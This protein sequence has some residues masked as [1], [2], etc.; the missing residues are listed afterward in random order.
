[1]SLQGDGKNEVA[2]IIQNVPVQL[3]HESGRNRTRDA[4]RSKSELLCAWDLVGL[5]LLGVCGRWLES[6]G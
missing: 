1:M 4:N 2:I 5:A 6:V 3:Q